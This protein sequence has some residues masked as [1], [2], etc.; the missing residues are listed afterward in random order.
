MI[1]LLVVVDDLEDGRR[2]AEAVAR[3]T[4]MRFLAFAEPQEALAQLLEVDE[5]F[6]LVLDHNFDDDDWPGYRVANELRERHS[7]GLLLPILYMS[8][9]MTGYQFLD[10]L[11]SKLAYA[12]TAFLSKSDAAEL[13]PTVR[14]ITD[15]FDR[16][17]EVAR[18]QAMAQ[19][20]SALAEAAR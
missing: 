10:L 5:P 15:A 18:T 17:E 20:Y 3:R 12:P 13:L 4:K 7:Y 14:R 6:V 9:F 11:K 16:L 8:G 1:D 2:A 19:A